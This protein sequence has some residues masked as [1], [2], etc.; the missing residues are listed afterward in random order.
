[1]ANKAPQARKSVRTAHYS[2]RW[3]CSASR[4][5]LTWFFARRFAHASRLFISRPGFLPKF[6]NLLPEFRSLIVYGIVFGIVGFPEQFRTRIGV[7]KTPTEFVGH[8]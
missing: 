4:S 7:V 8:D 6:D 2:S 1:M 3:N 5:E